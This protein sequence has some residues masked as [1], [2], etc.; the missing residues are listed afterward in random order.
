MAGYI[1]QSSFVDGDT[2]TAAL[3]NNEYNQL[4]NAFNNAT[5][6]AH[7]GTAAEGPVIGLIGDAGETAPN[8]KVL[9]DTTNNFI[10]FYV[11]V[12]SAPVQQ[13][14]ISDGAI[15]PV[16]DSDVDLGTSSLYFKNAYIDSIT[17][18]G[19]IDVGGNLT[20][21]GTTTF[22][23]G[24][25]T[26]GDAATDNV[27]FG[28]D[29]NSSIIPNTDDTYDLGSSSQEWRNLYID[30]TANI[31]S[32]VADT[33]DINAGTID[34][35]TIA[36]SDIT[37]GSGK[38]LDV[39]AGTLT[40][41]DDQISGD[42]VEGG[43]IAAT[44]VTAL[45]FGSLNDGTITVTAF[46][47]EDNMASDS[48]TLIP[49][50]QSVKAY[51][52]TTVAATNEVVED[53]TP[54]LGGNLDLNSSDITGTGN[55]NITGTIQSSGNITGTLAT[56]AQPNI[57]S[58]GTL[59]ALTVDD[60]TIN[61]STISDAGSITI[62][63]EG[64]FIVDSEGDVYLD[65]AGNDWNL[66][67]AG[68]NVLKVTNT[69]G[70]I[71]IKSMTS[72][73]DLIF[74]GID[75]GSTITALTLDMSEAGAATFNAG[76]TFGS[77]I[78]VTGT[79][80]MDVLT[81]S[82]GTETTS[83]PVTAD[84]V[85]FTGATS[86]FIQSSASLFV[87]PTGDLVLNGSGSEIM[88]LKSG[89]V[90]IGN[91][92]PATALDVT[93]T[94][95]MDGLTVDVPSTTDIIFQRDG[96]TNGKLELDFG[97][98]FTNFNSIIDGFKLYHNGTQALQI[99]FGDISFYNSAGTSQALFWD[100]SAENL[101]IGTTSPAS[102][103]DIKGDGAE[104]Y[105][106]S[107]DYN[108]ARI[109]PRGTGANLDKGLLSLFD[110]GVENVRID[111]EGNSWFDGGNV[112]IGNISPTDKLNI[113]SGTNQIG[114][115][116]GDQATYGTLDIG[117]FTN[118]AFIGTQAG[119]NA[120]SNILRFGTSGSE[121]F[122]IAADGS[123]STPTLG[124]SNVRF[125]V[126][127]G[128]SIES[129]GNYNVV[130]GDEAG[131]AITTGDGNVAV[132]YAALDANTTASNNTAV[133]YA[134]LGGNTTGAFNTAL[135]RQALL[136]N[137][138]ADDNTAVGGNALF[139]NTTGAS[140][141]AVGAYAL[142]ANTTAS[143]N[144]AVGHASLGANTTGDHNTALGTSSLTANTTGNRNVAIGSLALDANTVG[145]R[146]IAVGMGALHT[147]NPSSNADTYNVA[148][149]YDAGTAVTTGE[150]NT[151]IG[152]L[153]GDA[154]TTGS[155]NVA[156]GRSALG[157]N[158]TASNNTA[159]GYQSLA[160]NTTGTSNVAVGANTLDANTTA[161]NNT[162][163]GY[164]AL[165][166]NTTGGSN[167]ALGQGALE[168]NTTA[169][170]NTA[171]GKDAL[172]ANTTGTGNT[173]V[174]MS[175]LDANT[176]A[177]NNT[178]VGYASLGANTTG[179]SNVAV[180]YLALDANTTASYGTAIGHQ[181]LSANTT[182]TQ[183]TA[184]GAAAL[185]AAT[186]AASN[187]AV[188]YTALQAATTGASNTAMGANAL[189]ANTTGASNTAVGHNSLDTATTASNNTAVGKDALEDTSTGADNTAVGQA[190]LKANTTGTK[191]VCIGFGAGDAI[192]TGSNNTIIGDFAG[193]TTLADTIVLA[194]GTTERMRV[195][196]DGDTRF[197]GDL[198]VGAGTGYADVESI[199]SAYLHSIGDSTQPACRF[200]QGST[201]N[202]DPVIRVRHENTTAGNYIEFRTDE[203]VLTGQIQDVSGT[204]QYQ[205]A[206]DSRLKENVESMTEGL[207]DVLA[208]NPVK[209]TW[210]NIV[211]ENKTV[212]MK[213]AESRGFLAQEL[214]EHYPWAVSEGGE[215]EKENPWGVDYGK[216]TPVLVKA[217]QE[218]QTIIESLEARITAL[219]S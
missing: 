95:T 7:D 140:N 153:A 154:I 165:T 139:Q 76:A 3:F 199:N 88:R 171:V 122:R 197:Y 94:A 78:D 124:T 52:D 14:Y 129:G 176:T 58:V 186:T 16:T 138:T 37:V 135:G 41:A 25:I 86:N 33:A 163:V 148:V 185:Q 99:R 101:G 166:T 55:I 8:N 65:A 181:A 1:R 116:T 158:T 168:L 113:S 183:N 10:E 104:I 28:A 97:A 210:K 205:S 21:T 216:L 175:A 85:S 204:M 198:I 105:L 23:G 215:N 11:E 167:T 157:A 75:G 115:D 48:A 51:V 188:G 2:I 203:N 54:Q 137:T 66:N 149:G 35:A 90:G 77:S 177:D 212:D 72:D 108:V 81:V 69:S 155:N 93:G 44:T 164:D 91:T 119:S 211:T 92:S 117:H 161:Q 213:G 200:S 83:I 53:T 219:E 134:S 143:N 196:E 74:K 57:T 26:M 70:D 50:Q 112:G 114:L 193:T 178:A 180:G 46:V 6:H 5:G 147:F 80:T 103:L 190:A 106:R 42:K 49:T 68:T 107:A 133:G 40:L 218:Q 87:Q 217:I 18:T 82:D 121:R 111:T 209:F 73:K 123:L 160:L 45:T 126:N 109:I 30:G 182:G 84:R 13:L 130:V 202:G 43:T 9:I 20:V 172:T 79:A 67:S 110:T 194:S 36:T 17:T 128:N 141:V 142:D 63:T 64:D 60:I 146:N 34:G 125:G 170:N 192:T 61:G 127:A 12:S 59:S 169:S 29:I 100:A 214:N 15:I 71:S 152:G 38:T 62:D 89:K 27:V 4:L 191:N 47:D 31:D 159:V 162:A 132:G 184:V 19:N 150:Q 39:S 206:S 151:L 56:A 207:T 96:G 22:N 201:D 32:L 189:T 102:T 131:T 187:T 156:L 136:L 173:A 145:D 144:T 179:A 98:G 120:A 195:N 174:G 24:T 208:M 118:G